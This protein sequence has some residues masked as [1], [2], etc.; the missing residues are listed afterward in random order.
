MKDV[1]FMRVIIQF[2]VIF[3]LFLLG[4]AITTLEQGCY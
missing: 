1:E 4:A 3:I 2:G